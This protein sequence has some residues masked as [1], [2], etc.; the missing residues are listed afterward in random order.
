MTDDNARR[1]ANAI[2]AAAVIGAAYYVVR[3]PPLRRTAW[4]L[5]MTAATGF[6]PAWLGV[7]VRRAWAESAAA[8]PHDMIGG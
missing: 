4:R 6:V 7:E 3:V 2:L 5:L 8:R 1:A